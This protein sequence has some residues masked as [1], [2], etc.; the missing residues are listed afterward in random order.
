MCVCVCCVLCCVVC[1]HKL[2]YTY[3]I[4]ISYNYST[5]ERSDIPDYGILGSDIGS[6]QNVESPQNNETHVVG[7]IESDKH[8][9]NR[10]MNVGQDDYMYMNEFG[11]DEFQNSGVCMSLLP[12]SFCL[13]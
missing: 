2:N 9:P 6:Q 1:V 12:L 13:S 8:Y 3:N 11:D 5:N 10:E 7:T 4:Y